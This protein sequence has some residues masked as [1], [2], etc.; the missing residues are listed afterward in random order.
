MDPTDL[1]CSPA[2]L[3]ERQRNALISLLADDD[4]T[5]SHSVR[6]QLVA[7]GPV[8]RDWLRPHLLSNDPVLRRHAREVMQ[9]FGRQTADNRFVA[10]C[11]KHGEVLDLEQGAWLLAQTQFPDAYAE[12]YAALLDDFAAEL[13]P[14]LAM[15]RG[16]QAML[17]AI[18]KFL[19][20]E[21]GFAGNQ[22]NYYDP[23]N[24]YLNRVLDRR[25]GI[26]ISLC[27]VY[28]FLARRLQLPVTGIGLPGHFICRFQTSTEEIYIDCFNRGRL[29]TRADCV[30]SLLNG[31]YDLQSEYLQPLAPRRILMRLCGNLHRIYY[32]LQRGDDITRLQRYLVALAR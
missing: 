16:P 8:A 9:H 30:H 19:Y 18:N 29:M 12:A 1:A 14:R 20:T 23:D 11:L 24:S 13:R 21:L 17:N 15:A 7:C 28:L 10:F 25:L 27:L 5:I 4:A 31:N 22:S 32:H 26:P 2:Q 6:D 3:S